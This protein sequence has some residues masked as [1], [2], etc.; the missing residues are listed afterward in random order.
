MLLV[1]ANVVEQHVIDGILREQPADGRRLGEILVARGI[2][3]GTLL[4]QVLSHQLS[5]PWVSLAKVHAEPSLLALVPRDLAARHRVVPIYLRRD[6]RGT[7]L[8]VATDDPLNE[9]AL[10]DCARAARV[11]VRPMVAA[12]EEVSAAIARWYDGIAPE[13]SPQGRPAGTASKGG[14]PPCR[15]LAGRSPWGR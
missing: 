1:S 12:P 8:Y 15:A 3:T 6:A 13:P 5:L 14:M 9:A 4:T 10:R 2:V 11:D 7:T